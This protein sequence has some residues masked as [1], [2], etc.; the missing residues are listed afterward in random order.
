MR[1]ILAES[2]FRWLALAL[3]LAAAAAYGQEPEPAMRGFYAGIGAAGLSHDDRYQGAPYSDA[4]TG[5]NAYAGLNLSQYLGVELAVQ[6]FGALD[7][8]EFWGSGTDHLRITGTLQAVSARAVAVAPISDLLHWRRH[9]DLLGSMGY[10]EVK[11]QREILDVESGRRTAAPERKSGTTLGTGVVYRLPR[12]DLRGDLDWLAT[13][14]ER[15]AEYLGVG[16]Q[17]KF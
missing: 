15:P 1:C 11:L 14:H 13:N 9:F 10:G 2:R 16:V 4:S 17:F 12:F 3:L 7:S 6:R 5:L 8:G